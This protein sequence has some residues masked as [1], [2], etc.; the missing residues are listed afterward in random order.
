MQIEKMH[1]SRLHNGEHFQFHTTFRDMV[2]QTTPAALKIPRCTRR[3]SPFT[4]GSTR[5]W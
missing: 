3:T 4:P 2:N 5:L 1:M